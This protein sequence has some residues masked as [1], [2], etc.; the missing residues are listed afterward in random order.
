M[1]K[2]GRSNSLRNWCAQIVA[3]SDANLTDAIALGGDQDR[4][5]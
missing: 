2:F 4:F 5:G 3:R 1:L